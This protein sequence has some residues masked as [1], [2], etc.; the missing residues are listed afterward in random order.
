MIFL[1]GKEREDFGSDF[2]GGKG[3]GGFR[4]LFSWRE[5]RGKI[6]GV[7]FLEGREREDYGS[8]FVLIYSPEIIY[9]S[10]FILLN[11]LIKKTVKTTMKSQLM[12]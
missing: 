8:D 11:W 9:L 6:T 10:S 1:E 3:E 7:I 2:L 4:K 5:G 12:L